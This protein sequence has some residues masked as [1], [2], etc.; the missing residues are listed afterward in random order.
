MTTKTKTGRR[1]LVKIHSLAGK[2]IAG[3]KADIRSRR[4]DGSL[5]YADLPEHRATIPVIMERVEI[6]QAGE[7]CGHGA[8]KCPWLFWYY[9]NHGCGYSGRRMAN[10]EEIKE[11]KGLYIEIE[12]GRI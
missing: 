6:K 7:C 3:L 11:A 12:T 8:T 4:K 1:K 9:K 5:V 2:P 10:A